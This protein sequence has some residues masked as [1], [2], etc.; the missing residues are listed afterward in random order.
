MVYSNNFVILTFGVFRSYVYILVS[1]FHRRLYK[2]EKY[3]CDFIS[4]QDY[5]P[6]DSNTNSDPSK[7]NQKV[8]PDPHFQPYSSLPDYINIE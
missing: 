1:V 5:K 8:D 3:Y 4:F 6:I 7:N 2:F